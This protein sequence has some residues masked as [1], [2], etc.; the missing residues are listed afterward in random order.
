MATI[1]PQPPYAQGTPPGL[2]PTPGNGTA[3]PRGKAPTHGP[4]NGNGTGAATPTAAAR[5]QP[6]HLDV[7][8]VPPTLISSRNR[9]PT[10][11]RLMALLRDHLSADDQD[12]IRRAYDFAAAAHEGQIRQSGDP[13][14][15]HP[16]AVTIILAEMS[17]LDADT[18]A[19]ALLHDVIEDSGVSRATLAAEFG[20]TVAALV[21]GVTKLST[22]PKAAT[23]G[24]VAETERREREQRANQ[25]AEAL[26]KMFIAMFDDIRVVLIKL[27]DRLHNMRTLNS[28]PPDK[29]R[30]I[31]Q[32]TLDIY[33]PLAN[34]MGMW[35]IKSELEDLAFYFLEPEKYL[36][37]AGFLKERKEAR[38]RYIQRVSDHLQKALREAG[39][40][41]RLS[42]RTKHIYSLYQKMQRK[43]RPVEHIY[44]VLAIRVIVKE[45]K[46]CY[47]ALGV[48]HTLWIPITG[49]FD[50]YIA[51]PKETL[52]QSLHTAVLALE[53]KPLE[54]QIRT[55]QMHEVAE[56][57]IAAHW[58]YKEGG[59]SRRD[60]AYEAK[61]ADLRRRL[62]WRNE[63]QDAQEFVENL[64]SEMFQD[65]IY[66]YTP[67]GEIVELAA[68]STPIDFA[69]HIHTELGHQCGGARVND[70]IVPLDTPLQNGDRVQILK[71]RQRK[72]PNRDWI[73]SGR[74]YV[75]TATARGKIRQWFRRQRR[76]ENI[77]Q[78][79]TIVEEE[80]RKLGQ[81][82]LDEA[83]ILAHFPRYSSYDDLL[84]AIGSTDISPAQLAN[85][86]APP[87]E[88]IPLPRVQVPPTNTPPALEVGGATNLLVSI[89]RCC[90]PMPGDDI[91]GYTT[92]G[93]GITVHRA[94]CRNIE[95]VRDRERLIKVA[96][97]GISSQRYL[98]QLTIVAL[99]RVGLLRDVLTKVADEKVNVQEINNTKND[100]GGTQTVRLTLEVTGMAQLS[101]LISR[102]DGISGVYEV[103]R[104]VPQDRAAKSK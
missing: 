22:L 44:D 16:L 60:R 15:L 100:N 56:F 28:T 5:R 34:R 17:L 84:E 79:R 20:E 96:W 39:V 72:G 31:A 89:A 23:G 33:A 2:A 102:L 10:I 1:D 63:V 93:R 51:K 92:R 76:D 86:L 41:A 9:P 40:E 75:T 53:G 6:D 55:E 19:A 77:A 13:Y 26:R 7:G 58:R 52:Y 14:V 8:L 61:I 59:T 18:L 57:G 70:R 38:E 49:E 88:K 50:D 42:G 78:G 4:R 47:A 64:H 82:G 101:T 97:S 83:A 98:A 62:S 68:G 85:R 36:E 69:Y 81:Q 99:D 90:K 54:I 91:I 94:S 95:N 104:D 43:N 48:I 73:S 35:Q 27:A 11:E 46:D 21:D 74:T 32:Q 37:L 65:R 30:R 80:L 67:K 87:P 103:Y 45:M 24:N 3:E 29:Q 71:E 12:K 25:Q 66:V